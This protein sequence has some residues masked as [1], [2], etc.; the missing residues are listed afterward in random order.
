MED[1][2]LSGLDLG[3]DYDSDDV[4][5]FAPDAE[6][7]PLQKGIS[8]GGFAKGARPGA[9]K[10][11]SSHGHEDIELS[12]S[13]RSKRQRIAVPDSQEPQPRVNRADVEVAVSS[14]L[15]ST[16]PV[17]RD[18]LVI[19]SETSSLSS[20]PPTEP[21]SPLSSCDLPVDDIIIPSTEEEQRNA[22]N[23]ERD[24]DDA[25]DD[26][27]LADPLSSSPS[28]TSHANNA[29]SGTWAE[30]ISQHSPPPVQRTPKRT[31]N[32]KSKVVLTAALTSLLPKRRRMIG[33]RARRTDYDMDSPS[34]DDEIRVH[35][36]SRL[37]DD[38][39]E[40]ELAHPARR[41]P[42]RSAT[43]KSRPACAATT[44]KPT[45]RHNKAA[46]KA[47][48]TSKDTTSTSKRRRR[49]YGRANTT[50]DQENEDPVD[51]ESEGVDVS[52]TMHE[53]AQGKELED[54][55]RKFAEVDDWNMEFESMSAE[56]HRSS[57][58]GWR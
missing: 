27:I 6:G 33:P 2:T 30:P 18:I 51:E 7:T 57:S 22:Q 10:R 4:D 31:R 16:S 50:S 28:R 56:D 35:H 29:P 41:P 24:D 3:L 53:V 34:D 55:R 25:T 37:F 21:P 13:G 32:A 54:A 23:V 5:D 19:N 9:K 43:A 40:D 49:T 20:T 17:N 26:Q 12:S 48:A 8:E 1:S 39:D 15:H 46:S 47:P 58:Q 14:P 52:T 44:E 42:P 38:E 45:T 11:S 36:E